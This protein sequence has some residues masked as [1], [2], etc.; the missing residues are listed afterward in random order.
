MFNKP[1]RVLFG[2][3]LEPATGYANASL[4]TSVISIYSETGQELER[5]GYSLT[6]H[7]VGHGMCTTL[8]TGQLSL[9]RLWVAQGHCCRSEHIQRRP[10]HIPDCQ[11]YWKSKLLC[12]QTGKEEVTGFDLC[13]PKERICSRFQISL[14]GHQCMAS[15]KAV[16]HS[17][18]SLTPCQPHI[19]LISA[20]PSSSP[21]RA[22]QQV[23]PYV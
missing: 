7:H 17:A 12:L 15:S 6:A 14:K 2:S 16:V 22:I 20:C 18:T 3:F 23:I 13:K 11:G 21:N 8:V 19:V 4:E 1:D 5:Q 9:H 10:S